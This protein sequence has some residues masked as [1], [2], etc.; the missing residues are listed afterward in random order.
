[1][2]Y[3]DLADDRGFFDEDLGDGDLVVQVRD[4]LELAP[5]LRAREGI[6]VEHLAVRVP[7]AADG[8]R[9]QEPA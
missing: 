8:L 2:P 6:D 1:V 3:I 5:A 4:D 7:R 9:A